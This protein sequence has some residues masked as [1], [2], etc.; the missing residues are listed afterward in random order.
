MNSGLSDVAKTQEAPTIK[1]VG[2]MSDNPIERTCG[3]TT[4]RLWDKLPLPLPVT[5]TLPGQRP[6]SEKVHLRFFNYVN[7]NPNRFFISP[8]RFCQGN[9]FPFWKIHFYS[10]QEAK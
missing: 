10:V 8:Y 3:I 5:V 9:R 7:Y 1:T 2:A 4:Q 6:A